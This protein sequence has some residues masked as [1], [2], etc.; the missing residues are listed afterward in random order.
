MP[1][2]LKRIYIKDNSKAPNSGERNVAVGGK[3]DALELNDEETS[4]LMTKGEDRWKIPFGNCCYVV[5]ADA[6]YL[7]VKDRE[8]QKMAEHEALMQRSHAVGSPSQIPGVVHVD[9]RR[10]PGR[11]PKSAA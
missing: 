11:P 7:V 6:P 2:K 4:V 10:G 5:I 1:T 8:R 9:T 3:A